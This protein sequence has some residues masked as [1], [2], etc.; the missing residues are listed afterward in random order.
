MEY[1]FKSGPVREIPFADIEGLQVGNC[2][3]VQAQTGVTV[4]YFPTPAEAAVSVL[5]GGPASRETALLDPERNVPG[6]NALIFAGG[7]SF[8]L[9]ASH[10]V[11]RFL[12]EQ[13]VGYDTGVACV[14]IVCQSDI[15][16]LGYGRA[17]IRPDKKMGYE[18]CADAFRGNHPLD[19]IVG[20]G[21]GATIGKPKGL[22]QAQKSGIGY[23]AGQSGPLKVGV[24]VVV[25]S[26]GDIYYH[27]EKIAGM[28]TADR[29]GYYDAAQAL[30]EIQPADL[31]TGNTTLAAVFTNGLFH[32]TELK[33]I[34]HMATAGMARAIRPVF[35]M[36]DGDTLYAVSVGE[37]RVQADLNVAGA[38]AADLLE[39]AIRHAVVSSRLP[40]AEFLTH[41]HA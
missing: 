3:D 10:G 39:E 32:T 5:G 31:L 9:E 41:I 13:G 20:A 27:G 29:S 33:K 40:D 18:A 12:E 1:S 37:R 11:M 16:D 30:Y 22:S 17:D 2:Q 21:T 24:A 38:L 25:N 19:G 14:P 23:A 15:F 35:T 26:F 36:A 7:S 8:G 34:S 4:F 6:L 28:T